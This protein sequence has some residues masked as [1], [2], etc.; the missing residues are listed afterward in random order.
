MA[1]WTEIGDRVFVRRYAF[2]DQNIVVVLGGAEALVLDT[3]TTHRQAREILDD[4]RELGSPPVGIVVNTHGHYDHAFGNA[5]F[6]PAAIWGHERCATM[7]TTGGEEA[8]RR[9]AQ[10]IPEIAEDLADVRLDPPERT[11]SRRATICLDD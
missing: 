10:E 5:V 9:V 3:R 8:R 2:Y 7:I 4:L 6:R 11:F 1:T